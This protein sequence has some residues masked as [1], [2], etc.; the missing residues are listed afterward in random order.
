MGNEKSVLLPMYNPFSDTTG[1]RQ[2]LPA[3]QKPSRQKK[4]REKKEGDRLLVIDTGSRSASL[5]LNTF[6]NGESRHLRAFMKQSF[7]KIGQQKRTM[8]C[9][10]AKLILHYNIN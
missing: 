2:K 5:L 8:N 6:S 1:K 4:R 7:K 3:L 10:L 9:R